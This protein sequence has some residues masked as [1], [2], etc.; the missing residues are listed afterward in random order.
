M[1]DRRGPLLQPLTVDDATPS[2]ADAPP[3]P[4]APDLG[5]ERA[6]A[7]AALT[8]AAL[9]ATA[10]PSRLVR[11][12]WR[13]LGALIVTLLSISAWQF[14]QSL[15]LSVPALGWTV[16]G[17]FAAF[18]VLCLALA[19]REAMGFA[20]LRRLDQ[21][22]STMTQT[23]AS[24]SLADARKASSALVRLYSARPELRWARSQLDDLADTAFEPADVLD[25]TERTL[26]GPLDAAAQAEVEA[27]ARNVATLTALVPM[28]LADVAGAPLANIRMIRRIGAIYGGRAGWLGTMRLVRAVLTHILATGAIAVGDDLLEPMLGGGL[29]GKV[30]RRFGEGLVNGALTARVGVAAMDVCRPMPFVA[31]PA[32]SVRGVVRNALGGLFKTA[33]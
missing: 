10:R 18:A 28:A 27:A 29:V 4:D 7:E 16:T 24:G 23:R 8:Q 12:F 11:W 19:A 26:L 6:R 32:P 25:Q 17:L 13:V 9:R 14:A 31:R 33:S 1:T 5:P 21:L 30:S 22:R 15:M 20:R 2:P 3:V